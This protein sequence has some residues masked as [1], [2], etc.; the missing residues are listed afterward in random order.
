MLEEEILH[1]AMKPLVQDDK[2]GMPAVPRSTPHSALS[3]PPHPPLD[4]T[5]NFIH[6][7]IRIKR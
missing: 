6:P 1:F 7:S 2:Q 4:S 5:P 3:T